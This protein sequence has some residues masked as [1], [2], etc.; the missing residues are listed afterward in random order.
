MKAYIKMKSNLRLFED[1]LNTDIKC[2]IAH[3]VFKSK[4]GI[5]FYVDFNYED[6]RKF[7]TSIEF[8][9]LELGE[10]YIQDWESLNRDKKVDIENDY[11]FFR[12]CKVKQIGLYIITGNSGIE[13]DLSGLDF[14]LEKVFIEINNGTLHYKVNN[15]KVVY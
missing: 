15:T 4:D 7:E 13:Y 10:N 11:L 2:T 8:R 12:K 14:K 5:E 3:I 1:R 6:T 9:L